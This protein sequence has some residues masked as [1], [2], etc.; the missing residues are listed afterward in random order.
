MKLVV[1]FSLAVL[2]WVG[3]GAA[4]AQAPSSAP[5]PLD[6]TQQVGGWTVSDLGA[7]PG[8]DSDRKVRLARGMEG[9]DFVLYR[10]DP[11][12]A[13]V[14]I[15]FSR[16]EGLT[17]ES[18]FSL[19]GAIPARVAQVKDEIHDAF[20]DFAKRCPPKAGEEAALLA[21]FD[22]ADALVETWIRERPFRYPPEPA[23]PK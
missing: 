1:L 5:G 9:V 7:R 3:A 17:W 23:Q 13:G 22:A 21:D 19:E 10:S 4:S 15:R 16:C 18:G 2:S 6:R 14:T 20:K 12:G 8:D 11:D